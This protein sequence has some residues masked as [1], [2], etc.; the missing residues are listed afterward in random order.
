MPRQV[1]YSGPRLGTRGAV[2]SVGVA[3]PVEVA[4]RIP[5]ECPSRHVSVA[6]RPFVVIQRCHKRQRAQ[7]GAAE[8]G[9]GGRRRTD[10]R[11]FGHREPDAG[12]GASLTTGTYTC[13]KLF[14]FSFLNYRSQWT[15]WL[16][17][18]DCF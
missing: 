8:E 13:Q 4:G 18:L 16:I 3:V 9:R 1:S 14:T 11:F 6:A 17:S 2:L 15:V 7:H 10:P 12:G 5:A